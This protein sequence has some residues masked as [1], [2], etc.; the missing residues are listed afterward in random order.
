[1]ELNWYPAKDVIGISTYPF[2][3]RLEAGLL[4]VTVVG[5]LRLQRSHGIVACAK[6][7]N[8]LARHRSTRRLPAK[9]WPNYLSQGRN[10]VRCGI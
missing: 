4:R 1:M 8:G 3:L 10:F 2:N 9:Q 5:I 6:G 7:E